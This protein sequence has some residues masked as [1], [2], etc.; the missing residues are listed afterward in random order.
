MV[1]DKGALLPIGGFS[2]RMHRRKDE[3]LP[4]RGV[5]GQRRKIKR[6]DVEERDCGQ[7]RDPLSGTGPDL[8]S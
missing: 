1:S 6:P 5:E 3:S 2:S 7:S 8:I 4:S